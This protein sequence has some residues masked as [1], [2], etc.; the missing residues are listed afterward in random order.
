MSFAGY[1]EKDMQVEV[2]VVGAERSTKKG[3]F[4]AS[5]PL[6]MCHMASPLQAIY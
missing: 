1:F 4:F 6:C 3:N 2:I 5:S